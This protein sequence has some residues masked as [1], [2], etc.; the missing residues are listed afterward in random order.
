VEAHTV[1]FRGSELFQQWRAPVG[2]F[3][4]TPPVVTHYEA[5][6]DPVQSA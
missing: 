2:E 6:R 3:F 5:E 1:D 4:A